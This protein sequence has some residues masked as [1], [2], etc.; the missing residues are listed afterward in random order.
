MALRLRKTAL[1]AF[2]GPGEYRGSGPG[3]ELILERL[4][5]PTLQFSR[6]IRE[7]ISD[8]ALLQTIPPC[9]LALRHAMPGWVLAV[10][11]IFAGAPAD[12]PATVGRT[13]T[14]GGGNGSGQGMASDSAESV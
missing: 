5:R 9:R 2:F 3:S 7:G 13:R 8:P 12:A 1:A 10:L 11:L 14:D 6:K 4:T